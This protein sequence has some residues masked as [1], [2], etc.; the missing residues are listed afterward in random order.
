[1]EIRRFEDPF[2]KIL[3][4]LDVHGELSDTVITPLKDFILLNQRM[5]KLK[6]AV[7]H[8]HHSHILR[9]AIHAYLKNDK[10]V[11][12]FYTY[13]FNAGVTIVELTPYVKLL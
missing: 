9:D 6:I 12:K 5:G 8:G 10:R 7:I 11:T 2:L 1:M 3:P 4:T 13:N